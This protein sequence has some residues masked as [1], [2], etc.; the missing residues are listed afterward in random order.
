MLRTI[1]YRNSI[2]DFNTIAETGEEG[3]ETRFSARATLYHLDTTTK[4]WKE[5][6]YGAL[7]LNVSYA[8]NSQ[9]VDNDNAGDAIDDDAEAGE[10]QPQ[11]PQEEM[12]TFDRAARGSRHQKCSARLLMRSDA[13]YRLILNT[14]VVKQGTY[15]EVNGDVPKD[16]YFRF[17]AMQDGKMVP[18]M[19][20]V[21]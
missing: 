4:K 7:K 2:A 8:T 6:G 5:R 13:V 3:E 10:Q 21:S 20:R 12:T 16:R 9:S 17:P 19:L 15:G 11:R 14:P 1:Y 18:A